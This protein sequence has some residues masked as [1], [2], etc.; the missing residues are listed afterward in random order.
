MLSSVE[1]FGPFDLVINATSVGMR[2][3]DPPLIPAGLLTANLMV[4]PA[5]G[6]AGAIFWMWLIGLIG[7]GTSFLENTLAQ[8]YKNAEPGGTYRG[9][10]AYYIQRGLGSR[11][12]GMVFA[13]LFIFCFALSFTSL[14]ANTIVATSQTTGVIATATITR[15][16][17]LVILL[18]H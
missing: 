18:T 15:T 11:K 4:Y 9:G 7:M 17:D 5:S 14:Q 2:R 1:R 12:A 6:G 13:V 8:L 10:P 3:T 16:P